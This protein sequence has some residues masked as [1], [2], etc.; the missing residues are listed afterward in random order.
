MIIFGI[1]P[2]IARV[3]WAVI[4]QEKGKQ[5][6]LFYGCITTE[7]ETP[8]PDRLLSMHSELLK[9]F[10]KYHPDVLSLEELFFAKNEKTAIMV[11]EARGVVLLAAAQS[12]VPVVS[13]SPPS[14]KLAICGYGKAEKLQ[15]QRM[16]TRLLNLK[17]IPKPDDTADALA[18]A[19]THAFSY[20]F[21]NK[22]L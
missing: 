18:I 2:G 14:I 9:L 22:L 7:K 13:Y 17:E 20:K 12:R 3:G 21:K 8:L 4:K 11:G 10:S 1:D 19:L 15:V 6:P 5:T 16:V